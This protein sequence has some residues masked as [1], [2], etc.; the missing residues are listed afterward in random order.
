MSGR[1]N[2]ICTTINDLKLQP[3]FMIGRGGYDGAGAI[4]GN[5]NGVRAHI[6]EIKPC[7]PTAAHI[8]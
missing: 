8:A 6:Q 4:S 5:V 1:H 3:Q 2:T 7:L